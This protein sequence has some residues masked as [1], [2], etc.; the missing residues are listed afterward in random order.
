MARVYQ[1]QLLC[2][3]LN[4]YCKLNNIDVALIFNIKVK[5]LVD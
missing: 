1:N 3:M 5:W 2:E 4:F